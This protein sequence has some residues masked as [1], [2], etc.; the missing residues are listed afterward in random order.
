MYSNSE[1]GG[2]NNNKYFNNDTDVNNLRSSIFDNDNEEKENDHIKKYEQEINSYD[3]QPYLMS[4]NTNAN[5]Y[6]N[7][8]NDLYDSNHNNESNN[9]KEYTFKNS[10]SGGNIMSKKSSNR[11]FDYNKSNEFIMNN[12]NSFKK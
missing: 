4:R 12:K 9:R 10:P 5:N 8:D 6:D 1:V 2:H 7:N 3:H 11:F